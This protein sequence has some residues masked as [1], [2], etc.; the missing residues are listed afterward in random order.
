MSQFSTGIIFL[1]EL[2]LI[3]STFLKEVQRDFNIKYWDFYHYFLTLDIQISHIQDVK[4]NI[5]KILIQIPFQYLFY[6][7]RLAFFKG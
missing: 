5:H 2:D 1:V 7:I 4:L 6:K 3:F